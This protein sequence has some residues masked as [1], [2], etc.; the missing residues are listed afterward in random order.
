MKNYTR[1]INNDTFYNDLKFKH[2]D[3]SWNQRVKLC[4]YGN[5]VP[6][7]HVKEN[8]VAN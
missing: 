5:A 4:R 6:N 8:I 1:D 3:Q 2:Q 7:D